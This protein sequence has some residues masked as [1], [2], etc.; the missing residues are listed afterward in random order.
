LSEAYTPEATTGE[1]RCCTGE[2][3]STLEDYEV[4][5]EEEG[6]EDDEDPN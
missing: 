5:G 2:A 1:A 6:E 4:E 3:L